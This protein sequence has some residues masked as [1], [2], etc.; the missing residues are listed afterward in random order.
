MLFADECYSEIY[1]KSRRPA[2][3][4]SRAGTS[5]TSRSST[6][7]SK[8]SEPAGPAHRVRGGRQG[9]SSSRSSICARSLRRRCLCPA[10][11]VAIA[12]YNDEAHVEENRALYRAKFDLADQIIGNRYGYKRPAGGFFLWLDVSQHGR[13]RA[14][15]A[16]TLEGSGPAR[17][18][19][20][21]RG[22]PTGRRLQS[23]RGYIRVAMVQ[24]REI[25]AEALHRSCGPG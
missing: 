6:R 9:A 16:E 21:L 1:W 22:A 2:H 10:Q 17:A 18:A 7:S 3:S 24:D 20:Q 11:E 5:P 8:R 14:C 13:Q 12:A 25:T 4:R 15:D 19:R 23:G